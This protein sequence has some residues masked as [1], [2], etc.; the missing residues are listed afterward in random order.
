MKKLPQ[1]F[2]IVD[3][4]FTAWEGSNERGWDKEWEH[5]EIIQIGAV[6]V[7]DLEEIDSFL[8]Y[9]KPKINSE[10]S[11]Y[12]VKLTGIT[13]EKIDSEGLSYRV[14]K[15]QFLTWR[16]DFPAYSF[17]GRESDVFR[18]NDD[19]NEVPRISEKGFFGL[20]G[21][22]KKA[23]VDP[24][25]YTSGTIPKAFGLGAAFHV[26]DALSDVRSILRALRVVYDK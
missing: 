9:V 11:E 2:I 25:Q 6:H 19:I 10:L 24:T 12:I 14:A 7:K 1:E 20:H 16:G 3:T 8:V 17:A 18:E 4:E 21:I 13:Q 15:E 23:G 5:R 26:H 22:F